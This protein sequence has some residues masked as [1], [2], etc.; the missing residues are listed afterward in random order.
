LAFREGA[1]P[2]LTA[3]IS[4]VQ[5]WSPGSN[6]PPPSAH[7]S[8]WT[9]APSEGAP[10]MSDYPQFNHE[11][12]PGSSAMTMTIRDPIYGQFPIF[13]QGS[14]KSDA[15]QWGWYWTTFFSPRDGV[16]SST[17]SSGPPFLATSGMDFLVRMVGPDEGKDNTLAIGCFR[18]QAIDPGSGSGMTTW[19][20]TYKCL[21]PDDGSQS[22]LVFVMRTFT[23]EGSDGSFNFSGTQ[24]MFVK[25]SEYSL[26]NFSAFSL[27]P[28]HPQYQLFADVTATPVWFEVGFRS[29]ETPTDDAIPWG[30]NVFGLFEVSDS[31]GL[32]SVQLWHTQT[33]DGAVVE[34][35]DGIYSFVHSPPDP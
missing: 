15:A 18:S 14:G 11:P 23:T 25:N 21:F 8:L 33:L 19:Y 28:D 27:D 20:S 17:S 31:S 3:S 7:S 26:F 10:V 12:N 30:L 5:R 22:P 35:S 9:W 4:S 34:V 32:K 24:I 1:T 6:A 13:N 2:M 16:G 29:V